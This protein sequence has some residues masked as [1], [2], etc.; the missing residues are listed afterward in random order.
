M[1]GILTGLSL[2]AAHACG[3][4]R[5]ERDNCRKSQEQGTRVA[6]EHRLCTYPA[7]TWQRLKRLE[8]PRY[9]A[10]GK[11]SIGRRTY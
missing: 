8:A 10:L 4:G 6:M 2:V 5:T 1:I 11:V 9:E 3:M 7:L